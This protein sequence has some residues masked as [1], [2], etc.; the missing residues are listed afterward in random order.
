MENPQPKQVA[1]VIRDL[2]FE[3]RIK[4]TAQSLGISAIMVRTA[5]E[6]SRVISDKQVGLAIVDLNSAGPDAIAAVLAA[7]SSP[8]VRVVAFVSH[9]DVEL[10]EKAQQAGADEVMPRSRFTTQLP[11]LLAHLSTSKS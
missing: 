11:A 3:S 1:V 9:V 7:K 5:G 2:I 6:L 8:G 4:A 10:A